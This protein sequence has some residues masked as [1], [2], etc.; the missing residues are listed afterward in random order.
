MST[1]RVVLDAVEVFELGMLESDMN[2][3]FRGELE[4]CGFCLLV[5]YG[6]EVFQVLK[7]LSCSRGGCLVCGASL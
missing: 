3:H 4:G 6:E 7:S 1:L 2:G 5:F